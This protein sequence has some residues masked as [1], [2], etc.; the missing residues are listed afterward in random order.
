[1]KLILLL[2]AL[3]ELAIGSS[4]ILWVSTGNATLASLAGA[5]SVASLIDSQINSSDSAN[6]IEGGIDVG[7]G[8]ALL[9][10][11]SKI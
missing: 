7:I 9:L 11:F 2:A 8:A 3:Y 10:W 5:P 4:E 6:Y 1:M